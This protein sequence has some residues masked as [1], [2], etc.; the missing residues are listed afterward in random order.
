MPTR[1]PSLSQRAAFHAALFG[2]SA[3]LLA[4]RAP[5]DPGAV[6]GLFGD[7]IS[8]VEMSR[9][10]FAP[11]DN[12]FALRILMP[13][14]VGGVQGVTGLSLQSSWI[15]LTFVAVS[16]SASIM[17]ELLLRD[18]K[19]T[20]FS[21]FVAGVL[22]L[23][24]YWYTLYA[25]S[26]PFL[27]DPLANL[28]TIIAAWLALRMR[29]LPFALAI[30]VG[31]IAK[32]TVLFACPF[33]L[34]TAIRRSNA[35]RDPRV[36]K[37]VLSAAAA[38]VGYTLV[39]YW[40][41]LRIDASYVLGAGQGNRSAADNLRFV[42]SSLSTNNAMMLWGLLGFGWV[43]GLHHAVRSMG[44]EGPRGDLARYLFWLGAASAAGHIFATDTGRVFAPLVPFIVV[45]LAL[46]I[47]RARD[48]TDFQ[49]VLSIVL[50]YIAAQL[51]WIDSSHAVFADV[52]A[53]LIFAAMLW[54]RGQEVPS[55]PRDGHD[56][57]THPPRSQ[58]RTPVGEGSE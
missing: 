34:I 14:L 8:Y 36:V 51:N 9:R 31:A 12:P 32:E 23:A 49:L 33:L 5:W 46:S 47:G 30:V 11:V 19:A 54:R 38:V 57:S 22:I 48:E 45:F 15:L 37:S 17:S 44:R 21:A 13:L 27:V 53:L 18:V 42:L 25:Y 20:T 3:F 39:R 41:G 52:V 40:I 58:D 4:T 10:T 1:H 43:I 50:I 56:R 35:L 28:I 6:D 16:V 2:L 26:S 24:N 55:D 29:Y 7:A